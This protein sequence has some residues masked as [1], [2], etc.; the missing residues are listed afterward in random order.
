MVGAVV[1]QATGLRPRI[2]PSLTVFFRVMAFLYFSVDKA[3]VRPTFAAFFGVVLINRFLARRQIA[4]EHEV[5]IAGIA[6]G[7]ISMIS[8]TSVTAANIL[9]SQ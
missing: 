4:V 9:T 5:I 3:G 1:I 8:L 7:G 6:L 2:D